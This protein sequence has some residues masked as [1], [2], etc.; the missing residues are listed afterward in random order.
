MIL[1]GS[2]CRS[3]QVPRQEPQPRASTDNSQRDFAP[4]AARDSFI[5]VVPFRETC[6][7]PIAR[8][9]SAVTASWSSGSPRSEGPRR[10]R[11]VTIPSTGSSSPCRLTCAWSW[12]AMIALGKAECLR[13]GSHGLSSNGLAPAAESPAAYARSVSGWRA[14]A[15][16]SRAWTDSGRDAEVL[17]AQTWGP[18]AHLRARQVVS[19]LYPTPPLR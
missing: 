6:H 14:H 9:T 7:M 2:S 12:R 3:S 5:I 15:S 13:P 18:G 19:R 8:G 16:Y 17:L 10:R 4:P 11:L 1:A